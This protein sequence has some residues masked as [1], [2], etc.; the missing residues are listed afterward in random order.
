[1]IFNNFNVI[2]KRNNQTSISA[3]DRENQP[4]R[5]RILLETRQTSFPELSVYP[6]VGVSRSAPETDNIFYLSVFVAQL[7]CLLC[8]SCRCACSHC[9]H[10]VLC[11]KDAYVNE[12]C[13]TIHKYPIFSIS[14]S[15]ICKVYTGYHGTSEIEHGLCACKVDNPFAKARDYLSVQVHKPYSISHLEVLVTNCNAT[16]LA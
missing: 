10:M 12:Y 4:S 1:M 6:R 16:S 15:V 11:N 2:G 9:S 14:Y 7:L 5:Q 3:A 13:T 8:M